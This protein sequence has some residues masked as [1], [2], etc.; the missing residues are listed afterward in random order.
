MKS[1]DIKSKFISMR[2]EGKSYS[3]ICEALEISKATCSEWEKAFA[4]QIA[5]LKEKELEALYEKYY[6]TKEAR[7]K[8]LGKTLNKI[9]EA[10]SAV[11]FSKKLPQDKLKLLDFKLKYTEALK[12]ECPGTSNGQTITLVFTGEDNLKD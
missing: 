4:A 11:D 7:I 10:L 1:N 2:G 9:N 8:K 3:A 5:D 12:A 6:M